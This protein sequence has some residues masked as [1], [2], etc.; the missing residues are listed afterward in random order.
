MS[1]FISASAD[2]YIHI[3]TFNIFSVLGFEGPSMVCGP[4]GAP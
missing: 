1:R 3:F 4:R 2:F